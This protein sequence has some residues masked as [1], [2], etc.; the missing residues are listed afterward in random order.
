MINSDRY[1]RKDY[2]PTRIV[3]YLKALVSCQNMM[4]IVE[5]NICI[6]II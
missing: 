6:D 5:A 3:K 1:D 2:A 4:F